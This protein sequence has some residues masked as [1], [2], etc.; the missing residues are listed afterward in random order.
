[1]ELEVVVGLGLTGRD[2]NFF[3]LLF[4]ILEN[5]FVHLLF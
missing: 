4:K 2:I 5:Y 1:V 3:L